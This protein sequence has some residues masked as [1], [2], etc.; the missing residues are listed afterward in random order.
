[1][2]SFILRHP[3]L[4]V[5]TE[6]GA[7]LVRSPSATRSGLSSTVRIRTPSAAS[8]FAAAALFATLRLNASSL[9]F[10]ALVARCCRLQHVLH[11]HCSLSHGRLF[12]ASRL[13]SHT[14]QSTA[15]SNEGV[16]R[17]RMHDVARIRTHLRA[18]VGIGCVHWGEGGEGQSTARTPWFASREANSNASFWKHHGQAAG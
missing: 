3:R 14:L 9:A 18:T 5:K 2:H 17:A 15:S 4:T 8:L 11:T 10:S 7:S 12:S 1:V 16:K 13:L 6:Q